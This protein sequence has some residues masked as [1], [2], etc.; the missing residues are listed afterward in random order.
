MLGIIDT[1]TKVGIN[2][3]IEVCVK[4]TSVDEEHIEI[5]IKVCQWSRNE[6]CDTPKTVCKIQTRVEKSDKYNYAKMV[7]DYVSTALTELE[8][9]KTREYDN[10]GEGK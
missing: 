10:G 7:L 9:Q 4:E 1:T 5:K 6:D 8:L 3:D 2:N